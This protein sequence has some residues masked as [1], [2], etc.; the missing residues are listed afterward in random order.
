MKNRDPFPQSGW[1]S[2]IELLSILVG[3][4]RFIQGLAVE[5]ITYHG[6]LADLDDRLFRPQPSWNLID[7]G[8]RTLLHA[9]EHDVIRNP[10]NINNGITII[11]IASNI[12]GPWYI[13]RE[14]IYIW[15]RSFNFE[16]QMFD[17]DVQEY[18]RFRQPK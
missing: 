9:Y 6:N 15:D 5:N 10:K 16:L 13:H 1:N 3:N 11:T 4:S 12:Q 18:G 17:G 7:T 14:D 8:F 2:R